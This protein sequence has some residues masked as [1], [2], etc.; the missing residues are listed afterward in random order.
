[1][2]IL[3]SI[4]VVRTQ[5]KL[6]DAVEFQRRYCENSFALGDAYVI[7]LYQHVQYLFVKNLDKIKHLNVVLKALYL[8]QV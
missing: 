2:K 8:L 7:P 5:D 3:S 6:F 4:C 1:M